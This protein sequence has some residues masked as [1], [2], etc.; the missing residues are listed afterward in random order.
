M[1]LRALEIQSLDVKQASARILLH[2]HKNV[3]EADDQSQHVT[4]TRHDIHHPSH[5]VVAMVIV[6]AGVESTN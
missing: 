4:V 2:D 6:V 3:C 1:A 5:Q